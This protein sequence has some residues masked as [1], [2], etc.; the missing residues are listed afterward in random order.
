[1]KTR[2]TPKT[3]VPTSRMSD[4]QTRGAKRGVSNRKTYSEKEK[5]DICQK[6]L[7]FIG[8]GKSIL[9]FCDHEKLPFSSVYDWL[10]DEELSGNSLARAMQTGTHALAQKALQELEGTTTE[11]YQAVKTKLDGYLRLAG[12]WNPKAYGDKQEIEHTHNMPDFGA[13]SAERR[14]EFRRLLSEPDVRGLPA[15]PVTIVQDPEG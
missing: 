10:T 4:S 1:M 2:L 9:S 12:K 14:A 3:T 6:A 7:E 8:Q 15:P 11:N 13:M 5:K